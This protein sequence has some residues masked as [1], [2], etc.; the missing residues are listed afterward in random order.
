M[1]DV[2]GKMIDAIVKRKRDLTPWET[3][4]IFGHDNKPGLKDRWTLSEKQKT[5]LK[6]VYRERVPNGR[7]DGQI[8]DLARG[9]VRLEQTSSGTQI[10]LYDISVGHA[11]VRRDAE[12]I[13]MWLDSALE[14]LKGILDL[15]GSV[16]KAKEILNKDKKKQ[17]TK[18]EK[19]EDPF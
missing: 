4:F 19:K 8:A 7:L 14:D 10:Y 18:P 5:R 13:A 12:I 3:E 11:T 2:Y 16:A 9:R 17:A 1:E 6:Q 15:D